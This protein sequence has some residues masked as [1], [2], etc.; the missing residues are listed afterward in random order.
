MHII[1]KKIPAEMFLIPC[2]LLYRGVYYALKS[3]PPPF[4]QKI[5]FFPLVVP[6]FGVLF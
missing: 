6:F 1:K 5:Y 3:L 2:L 4:L